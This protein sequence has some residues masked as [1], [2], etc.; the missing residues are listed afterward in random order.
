[1][2]ATQDEGALLGRIESYLDGQ[3]AP[4]KEPVAE[5]VQEEAVETEVPAEVEAEAEQEQKEDVQDD[6][7]ESQIELSTFAQILGVDEDRLDVDEDGTVYV[8][9]KID[10]QEGRAKFQDLVKSYQLEGHLNK[11]NMEVAEARKALQAQMEAVE[12][13]AQARIQQLEDV[14]RLAYQELQREYQSIDWQTLRATDPAEF[15]AKVTEFNQREARIGQALQH[16]QSERQQAEVQSQ[17]RFKDYLREESQKLQQAIPE[18]S[19]PEV[20]QKEKAELRTYAISH[21]FQP[22][23]IDQLSDHR[24][25][26]VLRKAM[27]YDQLQ[28]SKPEISKKVVK[29]HK[30]VKPGIA[31]TKQE[32]DQSSLAAV[33]TTIKKSGGDKGIE[34]YLLRTGKV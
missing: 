34:E 14:S 3:A 18:W 7:T 11:Q 2:D 1:M 6:V 12:Q 28:K 13:Q 5:E 24:S 4:V 30:L 9:T 20:A 31:T 15:A 8:K 21:G 27:M 17:E 29:A 10:G 23:E 19:K 26:L 25:V 33:K 22:Q 32:R 16:A